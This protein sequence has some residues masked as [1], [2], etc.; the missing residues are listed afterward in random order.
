MAQPMVK[1]THPVI[2]R[3]FRPAPWFRNGSVTARPPLPGGGRLPGAGHL[4]TRH[5]PTAR[6]AGRAAAL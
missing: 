6:A 5:H 1:N 3:D 4:A 2:F